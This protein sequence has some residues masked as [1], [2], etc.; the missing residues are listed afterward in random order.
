MQG[1]IPEEQQFLPE[2][3]PS[4][5]AGTAPGV[6]GKLGQTTMT[7]SGSETDEDGIWGLSVK[8]QAYKRAGVNLQCLSLSHRGTSES[9]WSQ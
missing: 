3:I 9:W 6:T 8:D 4:G 5:N 7:G 1:R 2:R